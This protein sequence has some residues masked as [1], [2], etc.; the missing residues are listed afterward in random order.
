MPGPLSLTRVRHIDVDAL[1]LFDAI[2]RLFP[3]SP[4]D[5][6][7]PPGRLPTL[8]GLAPGLRRLLESG[9]PERCLVGEQDRRHLV[10][11]DRRRRVVYVLSPRLPY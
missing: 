6:D 2:D 7:P 9:D 5:R 3:S 4:D 11:E 10:V 1:D 8:V